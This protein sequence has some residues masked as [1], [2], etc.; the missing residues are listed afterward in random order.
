VLQNVAGFLSQT[1]EGKILL[2]GIVYLHRI[3]DVRM[4]GSSLRN[5]NMFKELCGESFYK[6]VVLATTRWELLP[7]DG[8]DADAGAKR[9]KELV[10]NPKFWKTMKQRGSAVFR[11]LNNPQSAA[12][13]LEYLLAQDS[14]V[15]T[16]LQQEIVDGG[17][18]LI[19]TGAGYIVGKEL[20]EER[21][22]NRK[23]VEELRELQ[24]D[25]LEAKD[26]ELRKE[27]RDQE[28]EH[29]AELQRANKALDKMESDLQD[30][31]SEAEKKHQKLQEELRQNEAS[32]KK[33]LTEYNK[34]IAD[35]EQT[36]AV[37]TEQLN[38]MLNE[39]E[40]LRKEI[41][42]MK[43]SSSLGRGVVAAV[44]GVIAAGSLL[45]G[46]IPGMFLGTGIVS[47]ALGD[48]D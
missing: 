24:R 5:F 45:I 33:K 42:A 39:R 36:G 28:L 7:K 37:T 13:I 6:N 11:H 38:G 17:R 26:E 29:E 3:T 35:L 16:R 8:P 1:Y 46:N 12:Q 32:H 47:G 25:A 44:G 34:K 18:R 23:A 4:A 20:F 2:S 9:E 15:A 48:S 41:E 21:E 19:E 10:E 22:K 30:L 31:K 27:L 43:N 40:L 14:K